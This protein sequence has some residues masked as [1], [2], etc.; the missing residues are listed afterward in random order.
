MTVNKERV[1]HNLDKLTQLK[2]ARII[3]LSKIVNINSLLYFSFYENFKNYLTGNL[4]ETY[5]VN[6]C[7]VLPSR[8]VFQDLSF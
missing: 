2:S 5:L 7:F 1:S 6:I 4:N 8:T 3:Y